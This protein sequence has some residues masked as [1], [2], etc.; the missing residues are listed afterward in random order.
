MAKVTPLRAAFG[1]QNLGEFKAVNFSMFNEEDLAK[2]AALRNRANNAANGINIEMMREY[3]RKSTVIEG[4]GEGQVTTSSEEIVLVVQYW[5]KAVK[6]QKGD[7]A[8]E[9]KEAKKEWSTESG[10][11]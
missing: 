4:S 3:S 2:Y 7:K 5:E 11:G 6:S 1:T 9:L 8:N 10:T